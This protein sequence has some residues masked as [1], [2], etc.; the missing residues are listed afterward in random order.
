MATLTDKQREFLKQPY[1][2]ELTTLRGDGSPHSTVVWVDTDTDS[3][4]FNTVVG[5]AKERHLRRDP[6]LSLIVVDPGNA[7]KWISISGEAEL[8]T[9]GADAQIDKLAKKYLG[10]DE[11]P[12]R[13]PQ[14]Q[15]ISVRIRPEHIDSYGLDE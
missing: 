7:Y 3:V 9:E 1:V 10:E 15:R 8:T 12:W 5:R 6:R 4:G 14:E 11:Y 2:G 13:N